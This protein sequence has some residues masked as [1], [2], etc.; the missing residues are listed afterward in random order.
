MANLGAMIAAA[1]VVPMDDGSGTNR[2]IY[3]KLR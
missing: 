2:A 1:D 3:Q